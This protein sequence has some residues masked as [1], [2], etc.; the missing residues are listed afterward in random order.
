MSAPPKTPPTAQE[1]HDFFG[2]LSGGTTPGQ[3]TIVTSAANAQLSQLR[4]RTAAARGGATDL[5]GISRDLLAGF[6]RAVDTSAVPTISDLAGTEVEPQPDAVAGRHGGTRAS[7]LV[8][9]LRSL[10]ARAPVSIHRS[11]RLWRGAPRGGPRG[12]PKANG[13]A[14]ASR[15]R[16]PRSPATR[17]APLVR[18]VSCTSGRAA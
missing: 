4:A 9:Y 15:G 6:K 7:P 14:R 17:H 10:R 18:H 13:A 5:T 8:A 16:C 3:D 11:E 2:G 1:L 12:L